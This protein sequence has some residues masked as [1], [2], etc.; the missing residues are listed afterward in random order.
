MNFYKLIFPIYNA[1]GKLMCKDCQEYVGIGSKILDLGCGSGII[2]KD[3]ENFF[4]ADLVGVDIIDNRVVPINFKLVNGRD[5]PFDENTFDAVL[6]SYV[7]HHTQDPIRV[8][9]EA[10]RV[11]KTGG[12]LLIFEDLYSGL[13]AKL[14]CQIHGATYGRLFEHNK[15]LK[16]RNFKNDREWK[17]IFEHLN[18]KSV[19]DKRVSLGLDPVHKHLFVLQK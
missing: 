16:E 2:S 19:F 14:I 5:L 10:K 1:A 13:I 4:A 11:A 15:N 6:I 8:L 7:L 18:F 12:K 17:F 3:F 9:K